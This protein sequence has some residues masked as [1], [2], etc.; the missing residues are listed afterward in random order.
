[1]NLLE[2]VVVGVISQRV[3][4]RTADYEK[5]IMQPPT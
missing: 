4:S 5:C 2:S 3:P 1:M